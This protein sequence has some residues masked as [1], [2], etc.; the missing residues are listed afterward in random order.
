MK[1]LMLFSVILSLSASF[2]QAA[3]V[4]GRFCADDTGAAING[5]VMNGNGWVLP[6]LSSTSIQA[7]GTPI[8]GDVVVCNSCA[9]TPTQYAVC[10]AT[11]TT[12]TNSYIVVATSTTACK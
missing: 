10:V 7:I 11:S 1:K 6:V 9:N 4:L 2:S 12:G 3:C 8:I 5:Q